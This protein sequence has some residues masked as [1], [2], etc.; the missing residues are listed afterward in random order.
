MTIEG[1]FI[2][3]GTLVDMCCAMPQRNPLIWG[4]DADIVNPDRW[5]GIP[6]GDKRLDPFAFEVFSNGP[7]I[8]MG[9]AFAML[10]LKMVFVEL[11]THFN[12]LKVE[13]DFTVAN[14]SLVLKPLG[15]RVRLERIR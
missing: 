2:P 12:F 11:I 4:D 9:K 6:I 8:C 15:L 10:E 1:V 14:P 5:D 3:K 7:R 13:N